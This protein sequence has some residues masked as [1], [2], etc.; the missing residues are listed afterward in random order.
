[1]RLPAQKL[2]LNREIA[3][4]KLNRPDGSLG[5]VYRIPEHSTVRPLR[6]SV[7][8]AM[9]VVEWQGEQ[10]EVFEEDL[11]MRSIRELPPAA[12]FHYR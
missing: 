10:Y 11:V 6:D 1:M 8:E 5:P 7:R 3:A 4:V 12:G 2:V 9:V